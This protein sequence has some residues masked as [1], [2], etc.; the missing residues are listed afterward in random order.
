MPSGCEPAR[1]CGAC[2][3]LAAY[4]AENRRLYP[5]FHNAPVPSFGDAD[6]RLLV[7][8]L[9]PGLKGANATGR[10][11]TGDAAGDILYKALADNGFSRGVYGKRADDG[12][13]L[14]GAL[15]TNA[16]RCAPPQNKVEPAEIKACNGHLAAVM[17]GLPR[18]ACV[19][20]IGGVAHKA[21]L[22]AAGL[23]PSAAAFAHGA[24]FGLPGGAVLLDSYHTSRYNTNTGRLTEEMFDSIVKRAK[25]LADG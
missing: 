7:V 4:L 13:V 19:L 23:K 15:I 9:A 2:P 17:A 14:R 3:R 11:F 24:E 21:V 12:F 5:G 18:L 20:A 25:K 10:P 22:L 8:G 16:V 1:D 6:A